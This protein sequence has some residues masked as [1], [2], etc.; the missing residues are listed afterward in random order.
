MLSESLRFSIPLIPNIAAGWVAGFS[1]RLLL[2]RYGPT[3]ETGVYNVG[4]SLGMGIT[5]FSQSVFMVVGPMIY[6]MMK[7]DRHAARKRIER[8][9]PYY[10]MLMLC[11]CTA[12]SLFSRE[13]VTILTPVEY[14][15]ATSIVPIVLLAYFLG[16]QY[17]TSVVLLSFEKRTGIISS[18][19][20]AR[21]LI[22]FGLNLILIPSFGKMAAAWT[23]VAAVGFYTAWMIYW[24]QKSF[25][26]EVSL[27]RIVLTVLTIGAMISVYLLLG[28]FVSAS[29]LL[30]IAFKLGLLTSVLLGLWLFGGIESVDKT[31]AVMRTRALVTRVLGR[32]M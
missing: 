23:T 16:S 12:L 13:I 11:I 8:F 32:S 5:L 21:A 17:Q 18:G 2:S 9:V 19:A 15:G 25:H 28:R 20:I 10:F 14:I 1:D 7:Q 3:A 24:S 26:L 30:A 4:Y 27:W 6:A 22:N 29:L 31:R